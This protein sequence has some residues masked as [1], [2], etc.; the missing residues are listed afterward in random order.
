MNVSHKYFFHF[1]KCVTD[2]PIVCKLVK[3]YN[4]IVNI[5]RAKV[6]AEGEGYLVLELT[7][8][9]KD[10]EAAKEYI[11]SFGVTVNTVDK[12][13]IRDVAKCTNCGNCLS[14]CAPQALHIKDYATRVVEF[15]ETRCIACEHCISNCPMGACTTVF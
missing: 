1:P 12:G 14:H 13:I 6:T 10:I 2:T 4:L 5:F 15:D 3:D 11:C 7:G 8:E 9:E